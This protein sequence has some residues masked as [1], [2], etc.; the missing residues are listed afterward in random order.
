MT[1]SV[2]V[3]LVD[4]ER[5]VT[6]ALM[7]LLESVKIVSRSFDNA[8]SFVQALREARGPVC[9]VLDLRMPVVSGLE[10]QQQ[11]IDEGIDVPLIFLSAHGDVPAAVN[12]MQHGAIDFLQKPFN[13]QAFL[14]SINRL[15][16]LAAAHFERRQQA[17]GVQQLLARLSR[18]ELEVL[19]GLLAG[20]TSKQLA[21]TLCIS[22]KT[23]DVHRASVMRKLLV[24]SGTELVKLVG[25]A[26]ATSQ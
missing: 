17:Q 9:A 23:V 2:Q 1:P 19:D 12:A 11:L 18:R 21:K 7:W 25:P 20:Q 6:D 15:V 24:S 26:R 5:D 16:K 10:L 13:S 8:D 4:D 22:P 14:H 3:F